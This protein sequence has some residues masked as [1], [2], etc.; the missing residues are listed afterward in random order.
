[1]LGPEMSRKDPGTADV[2]GASME[3]RDSRMADCSIVSELT[4][5]QAF[6]DWAGFGH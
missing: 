2:D 3:V 5:L 4:N 6:S 1:M